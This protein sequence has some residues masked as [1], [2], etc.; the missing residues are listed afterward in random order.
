MPPITNPV[1]LAMRF[2]LRWM[3]VAT[4]TAL[5]C[6]S[7]SIVLYSAE[8][9]TINQDETRVPPY[10]LPELLRSA[11]GTVVDRASL[12]RTQRRPELLELFRQHV[13][14]RSPAPPAALRFEVVE[15]TAGAVAGHAVRKRVKIHLG[16]G[17]ETPHIPLVLYLPA[18]AAGP[19]PVFVGLHLFASGA[20]PEPG[21]SLAEEI[22]PDQNPLSAESTRALLAPLP[23]TN[24]AAAI[25]GRG[26]GLATLDAADFAPDDADRYRQGIIGHLTGSDEAAR[27]DDDWGTI[28]AWAWAL[29]RALDYF[30]QEP[31]I[32][33]RRVIVIGHS[34][35]GKTALWAAAQ[36]E[37]FAMAISN[38]SGCGGAALSRRLFGETVEA[39]NRRF[40]HWFCKN[41]RR[42]NDREQDLPVDQHQ[43]LALV[44][45]RPLYVASAAEDAWA[46][47]R[48]EFLA[49]RAAWPAFQLLAPG[50]ST[51][52][53]PETAPLN[54]SIGGPL[55]Y[56]LRIGKHALADFDWMAYLAFAD[57]Y[58]PA[59]TVP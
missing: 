53:L 51:E 22:T 41:F 14:G 39:I 28:G 5:C 47:P 50:A 36:D 7:A 32:D 49:C 18:Q 12:W 4:L 27:H 31:A 37:R 17:G 6:S 3:R 59:P 19:V 2:K 11:D 29:S 45:P 34:R 57:R 15:T 46:D 30:Q 43:L 10:V 25:L 23:G 56:H 58:L 52:N 20:E 16:T 44:A 40:P 24:T 26:Y 33:A 1:P 9:S 38:N 8:P 55:G 21:K 42:Y 54:Q 13:Y 48:G 35:M